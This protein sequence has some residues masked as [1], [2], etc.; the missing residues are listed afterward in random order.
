LKIFINDIPVYLIKESQ[1]KDSDQYDHV[2]NGQEHRIIPKQLR[3]D[4]LIRNAER[5]NVDE[6]LQ[7]MTEKKFKE[8]DSITFVSENHDSL[9]KFIKSTFKVIEAAGGVVQKDDKYLLIFR[10]GKWDLPKG[11]KEKGE[12][13][14]QAAIREVEEETGVKVS[15]ENKICHTWHTYVH[16]KKFVLKKTHWYL[17]QC[18][19]DSKMSP[20]V[21]EDIDEVMWKNLSD[22]RSAL[23]DSYRSIRSVIHQYHKNL[24]S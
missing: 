18:V 20:Q 4:V 5:D 21:E 14:K 7:L 8:V 12:K 22:L 10:K 24:K 23:Y 6:L 2:L 13:N 15:I 3:D 16:H 11:K 17:M 19:D 1:A 9:K